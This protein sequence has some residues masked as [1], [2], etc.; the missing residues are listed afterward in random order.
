MAR[1]RFAV[2]IEGHDLE[3]SNLDKVMYPGA[4]FAGGYRDAAIGYGSATAATALVSL[5]RSPTGISISPSDDLYIADQGNNAVRLL[6]N[7][8]A[9]ANALLTAEKITPT[10]GYVYTIAG[11]K[12]AAERG[13]GE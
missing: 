3:L 12:S 13:P 9:A 5:L 7:G 6:Y 1:E 4:G 11:G 8:G 10:K 2:Q